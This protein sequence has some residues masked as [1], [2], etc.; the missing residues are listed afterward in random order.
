MI[1]EYTQWPGEKV[2]YEQEIENDT[3]ASAEWTITPTGPT[4]SGK[5][6]GSTSSRILVSGL[7]A[8]K[9]YLLTA[10]IV[11]VSTAEREGVARISALAKR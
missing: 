7:A 9:T 10:H 11:C 1:A 6:N 5:V 2:F 4:L 8:G 3:V